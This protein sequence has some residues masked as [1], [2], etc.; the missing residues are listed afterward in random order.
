MLSGKTSV[1][2]DTQKSD[3][4]PPEEGAKKPEVE[5]VTGER[6]YRNNKDGSLDRNQFGKF[7]IKYGKYN[8]LRRGVFLHTFHLKLLVSN[9]SKRGLAITDERTPPLTETRHADL[10]IR[11]TPPRQSVIHAPVRRN[12]PNVDNRL[13]R[14]SSCFLLLYYMR[15][16][17]TS[18]AVF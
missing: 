7:I 11:P 3:D 18:C 17:S 8:F 2:I 16:S 1:Y 5:E 10:N 15:I 9:H 14:V 4:D 13:T 6:K 12:L